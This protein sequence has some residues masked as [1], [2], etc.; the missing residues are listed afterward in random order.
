[1]KTNQEF[2][3][4][5][6]AKVPDYKTRYPNLSPYRGSKSKLTFSHKYGKCEMRAASVLKG[7]NPTIKS[8]I[9]KNVYFQNWLFELHP[10]LKYKIKNLSNYT[11][12][13]NPVY[14][15]TTFGICKKTPDLL[16]RCGDFDISAAINKTQYFKMMLRE[17]FPSYI[18][19]YL[20][21]GNYVNNYTKILIYNSFGY[22]LCEPANLIKGT[23]P[24][25]S[26]AINPYLYLKN[27][28]NFVHNFKYT[29]PIQNIKNLKQVVKITCK[30]HNTF[31]QVATKHLSGN[32]CPKCATELNMYPNWKKGCKER[33]GKPIF[34]VLKCWG[35]N[36]EFHKVGITYK[37]IL[38]R[39]QGGSLPYSYEIIQEIRGT[40][41][42][43]W[44]FELFVKKQL[45]LYK[46]QPSLKFSGSATECFK[47]HIK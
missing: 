35:N 6:A 11:L 38:K 31:E 7:N 5:L 23:T 42:Q 36:E 10:N 20:I 26:S 34:Y 27:R 21:V 14:F 37:S 46:Y 40:C 2:L 32:G 9:D 41:Q 43:V 39:Y 17:R 13:T 22:Y 45:S 8:A 15:T 24:T 33:K 28:A 1:M 19:S 4:E 16:I 12:Y 47:I 44:E 30:F 25:I 3:Q 18:F 29:Y